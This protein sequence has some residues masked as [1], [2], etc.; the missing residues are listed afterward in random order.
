[1]TIG[2][3]TAKGLTAGGLSYW[4]E[5]QSALAPY[6]TITGQQYFTF[7]EPI[8]PGLPKT[9]TD[10]SG[11]DSGYLTD[12]I[13]SNGQSG[14]LGAS[15]IDASQEVQD[16]TYHMTTITFS[17]SESAPIGTFFLKSTVLPPK[18]SEV[19]DNEISASHYFG[20]DTYTL[21]VVPEPATW[22]L[23]GLG[24][25]GAIGMTMLRARRKT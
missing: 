2:G 7:T 17:L 19:S 3:F 24:G 22:P 15:T 1:M 14:D 8:E 13:P 18:A 10:S 25:V 12:R 23:L 5:T 21:S 16:G 9:F 6:I 4:L 20:Q 11:A